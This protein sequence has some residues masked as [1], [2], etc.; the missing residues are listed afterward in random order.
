MVQARKGLA[1]RWAVTGI[2]TMPDGGLFKVGVN[3][4]RECRKR[5]EIFSTWHVQD[6]VMGVLEKSTDKQEGK[7][8]TIRGTHAPYAEYGNQ[9]AHLFQSAMMLDTLVYI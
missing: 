8:E 3:R 9:S 2:E 6:H 1:D 4:S 5:E 7:F